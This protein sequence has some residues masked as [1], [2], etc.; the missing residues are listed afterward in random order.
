[1]LINESF[2]PTEQYKMQSKNNGIFYYILLQE[3]ETRRRYLK[4]GTSE[5]GVGRFKQI[6]FTQ[7]KRL[8]MA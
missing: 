4:I 5:R 6:N 2:Y 7:Y 3:R 1:M 8:E